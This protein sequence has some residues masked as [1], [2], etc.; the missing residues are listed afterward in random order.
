MPVYGGCIVSKNTLSVAP[1][2]K[3]EPENAQC[4]YVKK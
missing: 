4:L 1:E 2:R 3:V